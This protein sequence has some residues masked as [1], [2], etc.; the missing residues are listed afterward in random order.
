MVTARY[1]VI[2]VI[3]TLLGNVFI[4][5]SAQEE[6]IKIWNWI[7]VEC[8]EQEPQCFTWC[9]FE[10]MEIVK[11]DKG[12]LTYQE[13]RMLEWLKFPV[14]IEILT[15][16]EANQ[17]AAACTERIPSSNNANE[18]A[19]C[20]FGEQVKNC[21]TAELNDILLY[22]NMN[23]TEREKKE[24][25]KL[26]KKWDLLNTDCASKANAENTEYYG[27]KVLCLYKT[28][29]VLDNDNLYVES[30]MLQWMKISI[31][32]GLITQGQAVQIAAACNRV[33]NIVYPGCKRGE[34]VELCIVTETAKV[35]EIEAGTENETRRVTYWT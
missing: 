12:V 34:Q 29:E 16:D 9:V 33:N 14:D 17:I 18:G 23:E 30:K 28:M 26:K 11:A 15:Q 19:L 7:F 24:I 3:A 13:N 32:D 8:R 2:G 1:V 22:R 20:H 21:F 25:D 35:K 27:C 31:F 6:L 4:F 5:C 10:K